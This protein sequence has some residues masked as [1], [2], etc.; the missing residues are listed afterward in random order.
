MISPREPRASTQSPIRAQSRYQVASSKKL[1]GNSQ[2]LKIAQNCYL[3]F[4]IAKK[5]KGGFS[6]EG[7]GGLV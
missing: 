4:Y 3:I 6:K 1:R 5:G 7:E 2:F